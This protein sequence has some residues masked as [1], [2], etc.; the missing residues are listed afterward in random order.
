VVVAYVPFPGVRGMFYENLPKYRGG[1]S[2]G[3]AAAPAAPAPKGKAGAKA[4]VVS[5]SRRT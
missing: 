2:G 1:V 4:P 5:S 3:A